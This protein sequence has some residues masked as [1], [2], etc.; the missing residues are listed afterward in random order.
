MHL[1]NLQRLQSI[2][3]LESQPAQQP[4][5]PPT[6]AEAELQR[7]ETKLNLALDLLSTLLNQSL[8]RPVDSC[9]LLDAQQVQWLNPKAI[10]PGTRGRI[11]LYL[12]PLLAHPVLLPGEIT[13][14]GPQD[15]NGLQ[16]I[17]CRFDPMPDDLSDALLGYI[18]RGHRRAVAEQKI[19]CRT[20]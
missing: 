4:S 7:L 6:P 5:D 8:P 11:G 1:Q 16:E 10:P 9:V 13:A 12:H 19:K 2:T 14:C 18:F 15:D 20:N 17:R 3:A